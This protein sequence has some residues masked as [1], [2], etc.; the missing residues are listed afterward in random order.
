M[1]LALMSLIGFFNLQDGNP[2]TL[3]EVKEEYA[4]MYSDNDR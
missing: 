2:N 4:R 3:Q 1:T